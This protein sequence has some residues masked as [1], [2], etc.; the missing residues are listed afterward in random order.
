MERCNLDNLRERYEEFLK[1]STFIMPEKKH[2]STAKEISP[3][4]RTS[5]DVESI[6][7]FLL[8]LVIDTE[9]FK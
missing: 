9:T 1:Y 6:I 8:A 3:I 2:L 7:V 5:R 4:I